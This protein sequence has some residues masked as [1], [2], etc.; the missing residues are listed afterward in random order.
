MGKT[1]FMLTAVCNTGDHVAKFHA[2]HHETLQHYFLFYMHYSF[3]LFTEIA[4]H[5]LLRDD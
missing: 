1:P 5:L 2:P 4:D 3:Y